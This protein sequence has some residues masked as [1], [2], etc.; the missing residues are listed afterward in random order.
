MLCVTYLADVSRF[1]LD[2]NAWKSSFR[3][4]RWFTLGWT[5]PVVPASAEFFCKGEQL[6]NKRSLERHIHEVTKIPVKPLQS[7]LL[8]DF[9]VPERMLWAAHKEDKAYSL[10]GVFGIHMPLIYGKGIEKALNQLH[11]RIN[12][13]SKGRLLPITCIHMG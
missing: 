5:E 10:L 7:S 13:A 11:E 2:A 3:K 9:S 6:G 12:K 8:S 1:V 4:S